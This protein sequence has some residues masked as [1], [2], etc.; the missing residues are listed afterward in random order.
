MQD[1]DLKKPIFTGPNGTID[2]NSE[3]L[4]SIIVD[5]K[6]KD[7]SIPEAPSGDLRRAI[8]N[9]ED[10]MLKRREGTFTRKH[11]LFTE[12][13]IRGDSIIQH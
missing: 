7:V 6:R 5:I 8:V 3:E 1:D 11:V 12:Q 13:N 9:P 4:H 10:V 2:I